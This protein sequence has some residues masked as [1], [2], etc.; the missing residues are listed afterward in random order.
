MSR[1]VKMLSIV[2]VLSIL[3]LTLS[4]G[5]SAANPV[6]YEGAVWDEITSDDTDIAERYINLVEE[7]FA[8]EGY[9]I[10]DVLLQ[11]ADSW[12]S[13]YGLD[14]RENILELIEDYNDYKQE[15]EV[16]ESAR[17]LPVS[18]RYYFYLVF[19]AAVA[20]TVALYSVTGCFL[21][22]EMLL[23]ARFNSD[24]STTMSPFFAYRVENS[25]EIREIAGGSIGT[26]EGVFPYPAF[27]SIIRRAIHFLANRWDYDRAL[28]IHQFY[29]EKI[30]EHHIVITDTYDYDHIRYDCNYP[31]DLIAFG[32]N[33]MYWAMRLGILVSYHVSIDIN[34]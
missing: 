29:Y 24:E 26:G 31:G 6:D 7:E 4:V 32:N 20:A 22:A 19:R 5:A 3:F 2:L 17:F 13:E 18:V 9:T 28:S 30:S 8:Y 27:P 10:E 1:L 33:T 16:N 25:D 15:L 11:L 12:E 21:S 23:F 14:V 34:I